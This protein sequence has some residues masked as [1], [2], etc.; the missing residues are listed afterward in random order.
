MI[1]ININNVII[2]ILISKRLQQKEI[3]YLYFYLNFIER[4]YFK[5]YRKQVL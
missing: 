4:I 5:H 3:A 1:I 2:I